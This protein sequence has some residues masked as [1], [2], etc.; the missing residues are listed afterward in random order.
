MAAGFSLFHIWT[1]DY[2]NFGGPFRKLTIWALLLSFFSA[3]RMI[4]ISEGRTDRSHDVTA[5]VA[6]IVNGMV[7]VLYWRLYFEDPALVHDGGKPGAWWDN[8][9][10]HLVGPGLQIFDALFLKRAFRRPFKA[11]FPLI[12]FISFYLLWGELALRP[13]SDLPAGS[14]TSGLPYPFLNNMEFP[15][16]AV[17]Y[18][19]NLGFALILLG[20]L[21]GISWA[22]S[23]Y[24]F[25]G[26]GSKKAE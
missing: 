22:T 25:V 17:F 7:V 26:E 16:R 5:M 9:Y 15:E 23:R 1:G 12:G 6:G 11:L 19:Q 10:L 14:V 3:S 13:M 18:G 2:A 20:L 4:M 21:S 8:Y 24:K